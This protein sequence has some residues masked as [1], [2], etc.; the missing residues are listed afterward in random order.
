[1]YP[2]DLI[3]LRQGARVIEKSKKRPDREGPEA[4]KVTI[5]QSIARRGRTWSFQCKSRLEGNT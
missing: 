5:G 3:E 1:M 2:E 4:S